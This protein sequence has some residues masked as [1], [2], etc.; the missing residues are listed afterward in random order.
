MSKS[1]FDIQMNGFAGVDFQQEDLTVEEM[2]RAVAALERHETHRIFLTLVTDGVEALEGKFRNMERIRA[3]DRWVADAICGYHLEG[4]W[5]SPEKGYCGA[6]DPALMGNPSWS[7]YERLQAAAGG[8]IRLVTLAPELPGAIPVIK[9]IVESGCAVSLGHTNAT[10]A[11]IDAA[12]G[13][14][15]KFCTHLGNGVPGEMHRH[16]NVVQRLLARDNLIAFFIPDGIHLPP[17]VLKNYF[18]AKPE[19]QRLF[20]TD[21]MSAAGAPAGRYKLGRREMDVGEDRIVRLPGE[22]T[23]SGSALTPDDGVRNIAQ[24]LG[25]GPQEARRLFS[26]AVAGCFGITLPTLPSGGEGQPG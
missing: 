20:T 7:D 4:P 16:N 11:E 2:R 10:D 21:C 12:I 14:G 6:H 22:L 8:H 9:R 23:F 3:A 13:A 19:G 24:W 26:T 1:L 25:I 18:R 5:I 17:G 15:A